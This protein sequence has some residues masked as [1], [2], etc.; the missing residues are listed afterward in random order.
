LAELVD[1][2]GPA[3]LV[4]LLAQFGALGALAIFGGGRFGFGRG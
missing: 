4:G 2:G 1:L 3:I